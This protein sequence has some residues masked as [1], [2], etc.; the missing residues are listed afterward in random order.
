MEK[1]YLR[2]MDSK[3]YQHNTEISNDIMV[4]TTGNHVHI[5]Q[6]IPANVY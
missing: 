2:N 1:N 6:N 4:T 3:N 5:C